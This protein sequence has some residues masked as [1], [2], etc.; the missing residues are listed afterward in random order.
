[1][2]KERKK[3]IRAA[4]NEACLERDKHRCVMCGASDT[5]LDVHHIT[6]REEMPNGG[7]VKENGI[8]LCDPGCHMKAEDTYFQRAHHEG[9]APDELYAKVGSSRDIA[10]TASQRLQ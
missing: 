5:K 7:Y 9:F 6:N 2:A 10:I 4:F 8:T 1:M 3:A